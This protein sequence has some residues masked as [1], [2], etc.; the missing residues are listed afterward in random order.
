[1]I[2]L[3][4]NWLDKHAGSLGGLLGNLM[5]LETLIRLV[6]CARKGERVPDPFTMRVGDA[7]PESAFTNFNTLRENID[8]YNNLVLPLEQVDPV[9]IAIRD[10]FAHG[11]HMARSVDEP[12]TIGGAFTE[13]HSRRFAGSTRGL[14]VAG[15]RPARRR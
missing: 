11:R 13:I 9:I 12:L 6:I 3:M 8:E 7:V 5:T 1:M 14:R 15:I 4:A 2:P 10:G